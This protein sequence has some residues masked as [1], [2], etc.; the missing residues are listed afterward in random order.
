MN[1]MPMALKLAEWA[2]EGFQLADALRSIAVAKGEDP[3]T[4]DAR[5]KQLQEE[6]AGWKAKTDQAEDEVFQ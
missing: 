2:A 6:L 3:S 1:I 4:F 5:V